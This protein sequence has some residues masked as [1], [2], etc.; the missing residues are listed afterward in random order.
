[1]KMYSNLSIIV[2]QKSIVVLY[3]SRLLQKVFIY[4]SE[5]VKLDTI[6]PFDTYDIEANKKYKPILTQLLRVYSTVR[7]VNSIYVI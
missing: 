3:I 7:R 1:M 6:H 5:A 2:S 4:S